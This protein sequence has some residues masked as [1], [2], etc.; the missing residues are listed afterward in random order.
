M[1]LIIVSNSLVRA[2]RTPARV[3]E[4]FRV[5]EA[6]LNPL[7][8]SPLCSDNTLFQKS[9]SLWNNL[10]T[11]ETFQGTNTLSLSVSFTSIPRPS[12]RGT[13]QVYLLRPIAK[14]WGLGL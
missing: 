9:S 3:H 2:L 8:L 5:P 14:R 7:Y 10:S 1:G 4:E 12:A 13:L 6:P 11:L